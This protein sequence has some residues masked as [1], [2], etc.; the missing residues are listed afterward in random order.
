MTSE[1]QAET[2]PGGV[3]KG[4]AVTS[5][6]PT[7]SEAPHSD[8]RNLRPSDLAAKNC[9]DCHGRGTQRRIVDEKDASSPIHKEG[10]VFV[11][12]TRLCEVML[13]GCVRSEMKR[14]ARKHRGKK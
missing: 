2:D 1:S 14:R 8:L 7:P 6:L 5:L 10:R 3:E 11:E 12:V 13:C 9:R 4:A